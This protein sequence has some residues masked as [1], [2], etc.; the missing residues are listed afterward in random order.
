MPGSRLH[1]FDS[2]VLKRRKPQAVGMFVLA[3][4]SSTVWGLCWCIF[5]KVPLPL[6]RNTPMLLACL[7]CCHRVGQSLC[8]HE[9]QRKH[10]INGA[11]VSSISKLQR[12]LGPLSHLQH[13]HHDHAHV[14]S[15]SINLLSFL[16]I[17]IW[18]IQLPGVYWGMP[19]ISLVFTWKARR[20]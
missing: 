5:L 8:S 9:Q 11:S 10:H 2:S 7:A 4:Q 3:R 14:F 13:P 20:T 12:W 18:Q 1:H 6:Q 16:S 19:Q 15:T 17:I